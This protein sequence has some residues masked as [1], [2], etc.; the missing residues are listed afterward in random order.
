MRNLVFDMREKHLMN[1]FKKF[2][3]IKEVN[4]PL[5]PTSNQN[6][7]FAF[8]E[9]ENRES[10]SNAIAEMNGSKFKGRS[11]TVEFSVPKETYN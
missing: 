3:T 4:V 1:A 11:L 7:G 10:A 2:G 6:R 9:F 8:V 5:N